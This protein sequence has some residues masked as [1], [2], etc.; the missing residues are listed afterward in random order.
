MAL[1]FQ[2]LRNM[3]IVML[4]LIAL[5]NMTLWIWLTAFGAFGYYMGRMLLAEMKAAFRQAATQ[6]CFMLFICVFAVG[7]AMCVPYVAAVYRIIY[8]I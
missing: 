1:V 8:R 4:C 6:F 3:A 7:V 5:Q 2:I